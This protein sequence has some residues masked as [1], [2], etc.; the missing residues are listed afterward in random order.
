MKFTTLFLI[1]VLFSLCQLAYSQTTTLSSSLQVPPGSIPAGTNDA[2]AFQFTL[3]KGNAGGPANFTGATLTNSGTAQATDFTQVRLYQ[4]TFGPGG[5]TQTLLDSSASPNF[6][7]SGFS[8]P[9][10]NASQQLFLVT[11][12]VPATAVDQRTFIFQLTAANVTVSSGTVTG[13]PINGN[14]QTITNTGTTPVMD[15]RD[16]LG[17]SIPSGIASTYDLQ[18]AQ[19]DTPVAGQSYNFTIH[20]TGTGNLDLTSSPAVQVTPTSNCAVT[21]TQPTNT[22][23]GAGLSEGFSLLIDPTGPGTFTFFVSIQN[24]SGTNPYLFEVEGNAVATTATQLVITT[25]PGNGT[26][27][28]A[29]STQPVVE[30]RDSTGTLDG[31]FNGLVTA[32]ITTGTGNP[33]GTIVAGA[34]ATASG[35]IAT[36]SG[37]AIDLAGTGYT[38]T[39]SATGLTDDVSTTFDVTVGPAAQ[40]VITTQPGDGEGGTALTTQPVLEIRDAGGN[41]TASTAQVTAAIT[42][43][44][45]TTGAT[46]VA[47][48]STNAVGG[49]ATFAGLAIDLAGT[50]YTLD[51]SSTGLPDE[52]SATFDV[53]VGPAVALAIAVQPGGGTQATPFPQ[54]PEVRVVDAGGNV[55]NDTG[56]AITA[57]LSGGTTGAILSGTNPVSTAAGEAN[58]TDL[59]ID[60]PG[61]GYILTFSG[62][63]FPAVQSSPFNVAGTPSQ[64]GIATQ[65]GGAVEAQVFVT[66]PVIEVR[67]AAGALVTSDNGTV[68]TATLTAGTGNLSGSTATTVNGVATF[69]DLEIDT[70]GS[71]FVIEFTSAPVLTPVSSNAFSVA[72]AATQLAITTQPAGA[73]PGVAFTTQPVI[74]I[75]DAAGTLVA[76]D[77][78]TQV[79]VAITAGTGAAGAILGGTTMVTAVNGV[80]TFT[81]L[82]IDLAGSNY[83]L[84]FTATGLTSATSNQ[85]NVSSGSGG[86]GGGSGGGGDDEG[87]STGTGNSW[88]LLAILGVLAAVVALRRRTA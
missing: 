35:G 73:A 82:S 76:T 87:C 22:S 13:G 43:G 61:T 45:G 20:N 88:L 14:T 47:G 27:G 79:T 15:V 49:V 75:R 4:V 64:L 59:E 1:A 71:G 67:D 66:Q 68:I 42:G 6:T 72:G 77:N 2:N 86:G 37:L 53:T 56:T 25:Q 63:G 51:F 18:A 84:E 36:F 60:L 28:S 11:I 5:A 10:P 83:T 62:G 29:L 39:F 32:T 12:D 78:T 16:A 52:T 50:N 74:E 70:A 3:T 46:I 19:G 7:F 33:S 9:L 55:T 17:S 48:S 41:L 24:N 30:A 40:L 58:F 34:T 8:V 44:T 38:L 23:I 85:F 65:P 80:V 81:D 21:P 54:Q 69:T 26:G 57:A 31:A